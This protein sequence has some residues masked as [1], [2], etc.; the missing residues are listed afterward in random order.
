MLKHARLLAK[1]SLATLAQLPERRLV[2]AVQR[3]HQCGLL[4]KTLPAP[5]QRQGKVRTYER[6]H[7]RYGAASSH[8]AY[9]EIR[10]LFRR[11]VVDDL[12]AEI[13]PLPD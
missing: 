5:R 4:G 2:K 7:G 9:Q 1:Q 3:A 6:V 11:V 10:Q 13:E 8:D 12:L